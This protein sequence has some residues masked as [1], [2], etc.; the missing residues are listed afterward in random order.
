MRLS[1]VLHF[2]RRLAFERVLGVLAGH[3]GGSRSCWGEAK[4]SVFAMHW[5]IVGMRSLI[6][7]TKRVKFGTLGVGFEAGTIGGFGNLTQLPEWGASLRNKR[8]RIGM[9]RTFLLFSLV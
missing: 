3:A 8:R 6:S 7:G 4:L 2:R 9:V 1:G 5:R